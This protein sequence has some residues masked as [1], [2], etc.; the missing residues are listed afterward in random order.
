[1]SAE[2]L[3]LF[4]LS[5]GKLI[6]YL[7]FF[8][9]TGA[10]AVRIV[11]VRRARSLGG[12][13][14][15]HEVRV[16]RQTRRVA[17][18]AAGLLL[19][20]VIARVYAQTYSAFGLDE[21]VTKELLGVVGFETRWG[22]RW[23]LQVLATVLVVS[24]AALTFVMPKVG[25]WLTAVGVGAVA[26]TLPVTGHAMSH[27]AATTLPWMLQVAHVLAGGLWLGT[28]ATLIVAIAPERQSMGKDVATASLIEAFSP[29][30]VG[31]VTVVVV[32][33]AATAVVYLDHWSQLWRTI[34]GQVIVAK[35]ILM[36]AT[37]AV[38]AYNW[39]FLKPRITTLKISNLLV[40]SSVA[41]LTLGGLL[42]V[43]TAILVHLPMPGE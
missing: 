35:V 30:A 1:M 22:H 29:V 17:V 19:F 40:R 43:V 27:A 13:E 24:S 5:V 16:C 2:T 26:I 14:A 12:L 31:A 11:V 9:L 15:G 18:F 25:W 3:V 38:G 28:L 21:P 34:Y 10:V 23:L 6:T 42:L 32:T 8:G 4:Y 33:G 20:S 39:R 36:L 7:G 41:E 37:G